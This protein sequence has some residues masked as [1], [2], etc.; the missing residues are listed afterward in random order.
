MVNEIC[1]KCGCTAI[2]LTNVSIYYTKIRCANCGYPV[3]DDWRKL[4][5]KIR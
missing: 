3:G 5:R 1:P 4:R 2:A